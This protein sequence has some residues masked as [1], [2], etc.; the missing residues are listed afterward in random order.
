MQFRLIHTEVPSLHLEK[1]TEGNQTNPSDHNPN[2]ELKINVFSDNDNQKIFGVIFSLG[3]THHQEFKL[4]IDY[5][6]WFESPENLTPD[7]LD[8]PFAYINA[9]AI[10]FPFLRSFVSLLTLNSGF[11]PAILPTVNFVKM[12]EESKAEKS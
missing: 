11:K 9:P 10:A 7:D 4:Q 5:L 3:L 6:A 8:S 1:V 12:Y 2:Y